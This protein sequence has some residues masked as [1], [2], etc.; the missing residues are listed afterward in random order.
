MEIRHRYK[1]LKFL[2]LF[3]PFLSSPLS[4]SII[5]YNDIIVKRKIKKK[6]KIVYLKSLNKH[7]E[8]Y[9][10][11]TLIPHILKLIVRSILESNY[12][13]TELK[14]R[15]FVKEIKLS[16]GSSLHEFHMYVNSSIENWIKGWNET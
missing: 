12:D 1:N 5:S 13:F 7:L 11:E 16:V 8:N 6:E 9:F 4:E 14:N 3:L 2:N 10:R 15:E